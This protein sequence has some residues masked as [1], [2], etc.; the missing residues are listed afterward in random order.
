MFFIHLIVTVSI[1]SLCAQYDRVDWKERDRWMHLEKL[2]AYVDLSPGGI[3]ADIGCHEGYLT[4]HLSKRVGDRG[5]VYAV[6]VR[7]DRLEKLDES[8]AGQ[9]INNVRTILGDYDNPKLPR[10][11]MDVIFLIDTYHEIDDYEVMLSHI[12]SALKP[13]GKLLILEKLKEQHMGKSRTAQAMGHTLAISYVEA[14]LKNAGFTIESK[15]TNF[16][17]WNYEPEKQMWVL[18]AIQNQ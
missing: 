17:T 4:F 10:N 7:R 11:T 15:N 9:D 8:L 16:G 12:K 13:N 1:Q 14:E 3:V 2:F 6:D 18:T 5:K